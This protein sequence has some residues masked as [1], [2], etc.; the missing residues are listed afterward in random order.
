MAGMAGDSGA[1][2]PNY[3]TQDQFGSQL[4]AWWKKQQPLSQAQPLGAQ[5]QSASTYQPSYGQQQQFSPLG[6]WSPFGGGYGMQSPFGMMGGYGGG[7]GQMGGFGGYG[8]P[9]Y[10]PY[11]GMGSGFGMGGMGGGYGQYQGGYGMQSPF[12]YGQGMGGYGNYGMQTPFSGYQQGGF[13]YG[14][15]QVQRPPMP[16]G[17]GGFQHETPKPMPQFA[18]QNPWDNGFPRVAPEVQVMPASVNV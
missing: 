15:P 7:Y 3:M 9:S 10:S 18:Q 16:R 11:G 13:G 12:G 17:Q 2:A 14:S 5:G 1:S 4:D 8:M 6:A